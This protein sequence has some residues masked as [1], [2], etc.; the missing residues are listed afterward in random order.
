[1]ELSRKATVLALF[2]ARVGIPLIS[3]TTTDPT[4]GCIGNRLNLNFARTIVFDVVTLKIRG[5]FKSLLANSLT[6]IV[7]LWI[8]SSDVVL[9]SFNTTTAR[10]VGAAYDVWKEY[11]VVSFP[12]PDNSLARLSSMNGSNSSCVSFS[13]DSPCFHRRLVQEAG[14]L[15]TFKLKWFQ[16]TSCSCVDETSTTMTIEPMAGLFLTFAVISILAVMWFV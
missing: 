3:Y 9:N 6:R 10:A 8:P 4:F 2:S 15:D 1:P 16:A 11:D 5:D 14:L 12:G 7:L 13:G